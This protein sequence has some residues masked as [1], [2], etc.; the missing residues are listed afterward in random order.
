[1]KVTFR[2]DYEDFAR[3]KRGKWP[4]DSNGSGP[5]RAWVGAI[6][7]ALLV[8]LVLCVAGAI[9]LAATVSPWWLCSLAL[10]LFLLLT[11]IR[12]VRGTP[13]NEAGSPQDWLKN[14]F[15]RDLAGVELTAQE[16]RLLAP[17]E[18]HYVPW[19]AVRAVYE[20]DHG[21]WV[22]SATAAYLVPKHAFADASQAQQ[23]AQLVRS[24]HGRPPIQPKSRREGVG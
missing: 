22:A 18:R 19:P 8:S 21:F 7:A 14:P 1:M 16:F 13:P 10:P 9:R 24:F 15:S 4:P 6:L 20:N 3:V 2:Y 23:F 5:S 17:L 11:V 12:A